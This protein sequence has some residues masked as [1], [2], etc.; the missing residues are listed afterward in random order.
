MNKEEKGWDEYS[1]SEEDKNYEEE[2]QKD[3]DY[4]EKY[5][6]KEKSKIQIHKNI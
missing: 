6:L 1:D 2:I 5:K 4:E 3:K